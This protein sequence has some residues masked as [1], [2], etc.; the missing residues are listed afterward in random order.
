MFENL[1]FGALPS[2][3]ALRAFE[4]MARTGRATA[5]AE[6]LH[7]THSAV[8][9]QVKAL[10]AS[11]GVRLFQGPKHRLTLT[12]AGQELAPALTRAFDEIAAAVRR[13]KSEGEDL[14][15]AVNAS[16]S[17]KWLIPRL[18]DFAAK[19][20]DIQLHLEELASQATSHRGAQAVVRIVPATR[21][22]DPLASA[23]I[24][25][26]IG[27]VMTPALAERF[28]RDPLAAPR[29]SSQSHPQGWAIWAAIAGVELAP[30][31]E[32]PF[33]H[34]HFAMDAA[35]AGLGVAILPWPLVAQ[36]VAE[37]RLVAPLGF[38]RAESAFAL[39]A[40]PGGESRA[41]TV[42]RKWLTA[43]GR[44]TPPPPAPSASAP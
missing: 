23:F 3:N 28:A 29:L 9:R 15:L 25:N 7:V 39:L 17:V 34:Q 12:P 43:Q 14:H 33:A 35:L 26:H 10:E 13:L 24:P 31:P 42:F 1:T 27:P 22:A 16:V 32:Q 41:L 4:A 36:A 6:E 5:A 18:G 11:L 30:A 38:R 21:L 19:H 8:S 20:P 40:A 44:L 2:L 37:G